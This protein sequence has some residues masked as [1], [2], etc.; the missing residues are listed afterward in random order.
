MFHLR[1][2]KLCFGFKSF[3][4]LFQVNAIFNFSKNFQ[5][6]KWTDTRKCLSISVQQ[7]KIKIRLTIWMC[8]YVYYH[9]GYV[10]ILECNRES[11]FASRMGES[12]ISLTNTQLKSINNNS[13]SLHQKKKQQFVLTLWHEVLFSCDSVTRSSLVIYAKQIKGSCHNNLKDVSC[14]ICI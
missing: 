4:V 8:V 12:F 3:A 7:K 5:F 10:Q 2:V 1:S 14:L 6:H 9:F 13:L 11:F